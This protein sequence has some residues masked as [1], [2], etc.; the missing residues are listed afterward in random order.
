MA[1]WNSLT[2]NNILSEPIGSVLII[3]FK[4][5]DVVI[6]PFTPLKQLAV[7]AKGDE[8]EPIAVLPI[9]VEDTDIT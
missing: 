6:S 9:G 8:P 3:P 5:I 1:P 4:P 7:G 2:G